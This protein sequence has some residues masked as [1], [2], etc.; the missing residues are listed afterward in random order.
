MPPCGTR[1]FVLCGPNKA[2]ASQYVMQM[3]LTLSV[4]IRL[5]TRMGTN[6]R[7]VIG[8][9]KKLKL[10]LDSSFLETAQTCVPV[11]LTIVRQKG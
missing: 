3:V 9:K 5:V 1:N 11:G 4:D 6:I 7:L 10:C 8:P 2:A